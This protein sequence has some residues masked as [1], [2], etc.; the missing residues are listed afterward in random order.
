M[1]FRP[2]NPND[3]PISKADFY[4]ERDNRT[5]LIADSD[6][7]Q[8]API[9]LAINEEQATTVAGQVMALTAATLA[10]RFSRDVDLAYPDVTVKS[11][12][13]HPL[14]PSTLQSRAL[15][16]MKHGDPFGEFTGIVIDNADCAEADY[17]CALTVGNPSV[18]ADTIVRIASCGWSVRVRRD[19]SVT[20]FEETS[21][22]PIGPAAAACFGIAELFKT[23]ID[24][25]PEQQ[26]KSYTFDALSLQ[27]NPDELHTTDPA[28]PDT[29]ELGTVELV[30]VGSIG[31]A[32]LYV[33]HMLPIEAEFVLTDPDIVEYA[34]LNRSPIFTADDASEERDK[35]AVGERF[36]SDFV[37]VRT[38][39]ERY[40]ASRGQDDVS[41]DIVLPEVD[42]DQARADIQYSRPPLM[43]E[44]TTN[45]SSVNIARHVPITE[46]CLLCH[47]PPDESPYTPACA[48]LDREPASETDNEDD[49]PDAALPFVSCLA[50]ILL[51]G[52]LVKPQLE[53]YPFAPTLVEIETFTNF[54]THMPRYDKQRDEECPFCSYRD[55]D[56]YREF[57]KGTK[58]EH[59]TDNISPT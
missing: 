9:L 6:H 54:A 27:A 34:N 28:I 2:P 58:F 41:P 12:L 10:S 46:A 59:L 32:L 55:P 29:V 17:A 39:A 43:L 21:P 44:T 8:D 38:F 47:F 3:L 1:T 56:Q 18:R 5:N 53:E 25:P 37:N 57:I 24:R 7:Y 51:A 15:A 36:I 11:A 26:P 22:N 40:G 35:V 16:E 19:A 30:G 4:R 23:L 45:E 42:S 33:L 52:E 50:G 13:Q 14:F 31:S 49:D 48:T 20:P